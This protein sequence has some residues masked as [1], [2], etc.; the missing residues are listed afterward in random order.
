MADTNNNRNYSSGNIS[1]T[2]VGACPGSEAFLVSI[3][4]VNILIDTGFS[5]CAE[6][7]I[8]NIK[9]ILRNKSLDYILLTHSHYDHTSGSAYLRSYF[10]NVKIIASEYSAKILSK[11]SAISTMRQ[12]N[13][14]AA[15]EHGVFEFE[16]KLS[17]LKVD[18]PVRDGD[19]IDLGGVSLL[20]IDA[21]GHTKCSTA[22]YIPQEKFLI[23]CET[24]GCLTDD[25]EVSPCYLVGYQLTL[26]SIN[27]IMD[28]NIE[29]ILI[30]HFGVIE[31]KACRAF[32]NNALNAA[33]QL[34]D[35]IISDYRQGK[36]VE[37]IIG[38]YRDVYYTEDV[39]RV[40]PPA[41][42]DLNA[43]YLVPMVIRELTE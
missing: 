37:E 27:K 2:N 24:V 40:Q 28:Y 17:V 1:V 36:S 6:K 26:N 4:H 30:P 22:F 31:D 5:F 15:E 43:T 42:F 18:I 38:H 7:M 39:R 12:L 20:V 16:D 14:S 3:N 11:P 41:A 8:D 10:K 9:E 35:F 13:I 33:V 21:P 19:V 25:N 23:S 34:K 29:K 32:L